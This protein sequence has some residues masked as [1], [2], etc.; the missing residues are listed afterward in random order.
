MGHMKF[1]AVNEQTQGQQEAIF[2]SADQAVFLAYQITSQ[3][4]P[5]DA[6]LRKILIR[7]M[8]T[9]GSINDEQQGWL[10]QLR[11]KSSGRVN[12]AGL[13]P[14][15]VRA[16]CALIVHAVKTKL[17]RTEM[18]ALQARFGNTEVEDDDGRRRFAFSAERID[19]IKGLSDWIAPS[20][21]HIKP[22]AIDCMIGKLYANHSRVQISFRELARNFGGN[23]MLYARGYEKIRTRL[24]ELELLALDRLDPYLRAQG[25]VGDFDD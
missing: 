13:S 14:L 17:P 23:H 11:G 15:E 7:A 6:P 24:R 19:A 25:V 18:W 8:E 21:P 16:Q 4:A 12:F 2:R 5:Q 10:E 1:E 3:D 9:L 22:F 20:L